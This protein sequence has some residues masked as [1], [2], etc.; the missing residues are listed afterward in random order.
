MNLLKALLRR[1]PQAAIDD[2]RVV[3]R[4]ANHGRLWVGD[5]LQRDLLGRELKSLGFKWA[6]SRGAWYYPEA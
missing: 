2:R 6:E 4:D 5:P 3:G 1:F